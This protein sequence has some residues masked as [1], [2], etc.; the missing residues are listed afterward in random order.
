MR[1]GGEVDHES[2]RRCVADD[3]VTYKKETDC[4]R[5]YSR[6][7]MNTPERRQDT[8]TMAENSCRERERERERR[9]SAKERESEGESFETHGKLSGTPEWLEHS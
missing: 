1:E 6:T 7:E 2:K 9:Q 5:A 4:D 3:L 8:L